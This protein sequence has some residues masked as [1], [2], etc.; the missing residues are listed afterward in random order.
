MKIGKR[1]AL[2]RDLVLIAHVIGSQ[3]DLQYVGPSVG[4]HP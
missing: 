1:I 4:M 3:I 2:V